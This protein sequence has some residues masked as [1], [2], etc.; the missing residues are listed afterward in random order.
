MTKCSNIPFLNINRVLYKLISGFSNLR[1]KAGRLKE[2][3][4]WKEV[5][6]ERGD[7]GV[8]NCVITSICSEV[9]ETNWWLIGGYGFA[10][11]KSI[12]VNVSIVL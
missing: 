8:G 9:K 1:Q 6:R 3:W 5:D 10:N 2:R 7:G 4:R 12:G 11:D